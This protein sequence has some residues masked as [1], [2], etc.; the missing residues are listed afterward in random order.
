MIQSLSSQLI[1][2]LLVSGFLVV[3]SSEACAKKRPQ[4]LYLGFIS[5]AVSLP[6]QS[7]VWESSN[8]LHGGISAG[9]NWYYGNRGNSYFF[10]NTGLQFY[11]HA[12]LYTAL[13]LQLAWNYRY[14]ISPSINVGLETGIGYLHKFNHIKQYRLVNNRYERVGVL[15]RPALAFSL[16]AQI[17]WY[18]KFFLRA[19]SIY[20]K[21]QVMGQYRFAGDVPILPSTL[22][23]IG[24]SYA[25]SKFLND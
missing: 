7:P 2:F 10:W 14:A 11:D 22:T 13:H 25:I 15:G 21:Y 17:N 18:P 19:G 20:L 1:R 4:E 23:Q 8:P 16:G 12:F 24:V 9:A 6:F 5:E 3:F